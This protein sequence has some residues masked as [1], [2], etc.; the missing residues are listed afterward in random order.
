MKQTVVVEGFEELRE[1]LIQ[2][3]KA[4]GAATQKAT[5]EGALVVQAEADRRAPKANVIDV[6]LIES[7]LHRA[8][9]AIGLKAAFWYLKFFESGAQPHEINGNPLVFEGDAGLV[10]TKQVQHSG[11]AAEPFL[12]PGLKKKKDAVV[13]AMGAVFRDEILKFVRRM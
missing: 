11:M 7:K 3:G 9:F 13:A 6:A 5:E 10:I 4:A 12:V 2:I 8:V 1:Q